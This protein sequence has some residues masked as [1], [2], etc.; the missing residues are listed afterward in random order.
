MVGMFDPKK[1]AFQGIDREFPGWAPPGRVD[2]ERVVEE[3][4]ARERRWEAMSPR[5]R[6]AERP[7]IVSPEQYEQL[8][9]YAEKHGVNPITGERIR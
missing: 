1:P 2:P 4:L 9:A 6:L 5:E 7:L 3:C 8:Q